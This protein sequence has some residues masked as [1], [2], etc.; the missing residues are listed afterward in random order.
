MDGAEFNGCSE[1]IRAALKKGG[2]MDDKQ[3]L[4]SLE[5][6]HQ[7]MFDAGWTHKELRKDY[8]LAAFTHCNNLLNEFK[9]RV[10]CQ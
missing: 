7:A 3:I 6:I 8:E 5:V 2:V 10:K 1:T 4:A 9:E